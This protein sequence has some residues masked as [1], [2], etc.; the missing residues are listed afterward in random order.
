MVSGVVDIDPRL[1]STDPRFEV[2]IAAKACQSGP[3]VST[4]NSVRIVCPA[5]LEAYACYSRTLLAAATA[6]QVPGRQKIS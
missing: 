3:E 5:E 4:E 1:A 2:R 6:T